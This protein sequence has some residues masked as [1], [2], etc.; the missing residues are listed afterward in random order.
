MVPNARQ[1]K[2]A[3]ILLGWSQAE[4]ASKASVGRNSL[5]RFESGTTDTKNSTLQALTSALQKGGI[6]FVSDASRV[7]IWLRLDEA[8]IG[9]AAPGQPSDIPDGGGT[10]KSSAAKRKAKL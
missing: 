1:L 5:S 10:S 8:D 4:L 3:R 6:T 2:A 9:S 7:G